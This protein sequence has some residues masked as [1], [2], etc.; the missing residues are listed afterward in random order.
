[1]LESLL[2]KADKDLLTEKVL[3]FFED[4]INQEIGHFD[5]H[6]LIDFFIQEI[7][8]NLYNKGLQDAHKL[9]AEQFEE[10]AYR[11]QEHERASDYG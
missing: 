1:M 5:A 3:R 6:F 8:P 9:I 7:G 2:S 4:E 11:L 10:I